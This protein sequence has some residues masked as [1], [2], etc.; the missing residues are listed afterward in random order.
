MNGFGKGFEGTENILTPFTVEGEAGYF[1][2]MQENKSVPQEI[3]DYCVEKTFYQ[4]LDMSDA[5]AV[6][7][8]IIK[9]L[10]GEWK[11]ST[12]NINYNVGVLE[13]NETNFVNGKVVINDFEAVGN[14]RERSILAL[15][16][17][18]EGRVSQLHKSATFT[19]NE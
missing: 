14:A 8:E 10:T 12:D 18:A 11:V 19:W 16:M 7:A 15:V 5:T 1:D 2:I 9:A 4:S 6:K 17:D 13:L 3:I